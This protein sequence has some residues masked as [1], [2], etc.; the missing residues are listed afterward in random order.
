MEEE[1]KSCDLWSLIFNNEISPRPLAIPF[2]LLFRKPPGSASQQKTVV[3]CVYDR[4]STDLQA[5]LTL[6]AL[7]A[8]HMPESHAFIEFCRP[9]FEIPLVSSL[10]TA[11][12]RPKTFTFSTPHQLQVFINF[13]TYSVLL[14]S[15]I[16]GLQNIDRHFS[17]SVVVIETGA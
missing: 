14:N 1:C 9:G 6:Y 16:P 12:V 8:Q 7:K 11:L 2:P 15:K 13:T 17:W 5:L 10:W 4:V 3:A